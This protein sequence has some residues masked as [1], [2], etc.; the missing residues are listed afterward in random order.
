MPSLFCPRLRLAVAAAAAAALGSTATAPVAPHHASKELW[1]DSPRLGY[2]QAGDPGEKMKRMKATRHHV[3]RIKMLRDEAEMEEE[4][5]SARAE[6]ENLQVRLAEGDMK[7]VDRE[8]LEGDIRALESLLSQ[9][10]E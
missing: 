9:F 7:R 4:R 1:H 6:L 3:S 8:I 10:T 5:D 2:A